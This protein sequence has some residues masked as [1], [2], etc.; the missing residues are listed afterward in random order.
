MNKCNVIAISNQKG[1]VGKSTTAVNLGVGLAKLGNRVLIVDS[2]PQADATCCLG[3]AD[4]DALDMTLATKLRE[5]VEDK[6]SNPAEGILHHEEGVD[7]MPSSIEL[8]E[9]EMVLIAAMSR[10][11]TMRQWIDRVKDN[12]DYVLIDCMP[13]LGMITINALAAADQVI[14]PV[15]SHYLPAKG[16]TQLVKTITKVKHQLNSRLRIGGILLTLVDS[17]TRIARTMAEEIRTSYSSTIP[18]FKTE[19]PLAVS[20]AET[21]MTGKSLF[22]YDAKSKVAQAYEELSK[23][24][25]DNAK[26]RAKAKSAPSR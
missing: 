3:W 5:V 14:I 9:M 1:G 13:S 4:T 18:I 20:A 24:V 8:S 17:R 26:A 23:E 25:N 2:D 21:S 22:A 15:Q 6:L 19:I 11:K 7:L 12:Y 10:E 16:M